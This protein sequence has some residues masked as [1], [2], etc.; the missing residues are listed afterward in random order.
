MPG[1]PYD[2]RGLARFNAVF[3]RLDHGALDVGEDLL[4]RGLVHLGK[5]LG[6]LHFEVVNV[7]HSN[8]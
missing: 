7:A 5:K 2:G 1:G 8:L 6:E 3:I 4:A